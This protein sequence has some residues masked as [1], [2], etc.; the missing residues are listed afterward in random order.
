[1]LHFTAVD[2]Y[3]ATSENL[4]FTSDESQKTVSIV[5][6]ND[7]TVEITETFLGSISLP[8]NEP[9]V[10]LGQDTATYIIIDDDSKS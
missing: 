5:L 9:G 4:Q 10:L 1:M 6:V 3:D 2:D 8:T 7:N